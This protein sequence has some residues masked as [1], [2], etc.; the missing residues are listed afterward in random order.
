MKKEILSAAEIQK[1]CQTVGKKITDKYKNIATPITLIG[2]MKGAI[3]FM[4]DLIKEIKIPLRIEF[5]Q[6][7][8]YERQ[9]SITTPILKKDI[10]LSIEDQHV[11]VIDDVIDSGLTMAFLANHFKTNHQAKSV[12]TIALLDKKCQRKNG[13]EIDYCGTEIENEFVVGYGLDYLD[14]GRNI[15]YVFV[16]DQNELDKWEELH[17]S[18][19]Q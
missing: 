9:A 10:S 17:A 1:I 4:M 3:P 8:S 19:Q 12:E 11:I 5:I 18:L 14:F 6:V 15:P 2:V 16:P 13:F 7:S